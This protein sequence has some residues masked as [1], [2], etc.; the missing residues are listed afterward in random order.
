MKTITPNYDAAHAVV[1]AHGGYTVNLLPKMFE[2]AL[3]DQPESEI[4]FRFPSNPQL[5]LVLSSIAQDLRSH[6]LPR[7]EPAAAKAAIEAHAS[8]LAALSHA[9][10][11]PA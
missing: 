11:M 10:K 1:S 4:R 3:R 8:T 6:S 7:M 9:L 2:A 5:A